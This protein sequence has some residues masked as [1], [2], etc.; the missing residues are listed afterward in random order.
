[1]SS[2]PS[3]I[4]SFLFLFLFL[5][6]LLP[7]L[8]TATADA[9]C[10][11]VTG[12]LLDSSFA[13]CKPASGAKHSGCCATNRASG[14]DICLDSGLCMSTTDK[15]AGTLWQ[16]GC[17]DSTWEDGGC[18]KNMC[19]DVSD[20][21][22]DVDAVV[23]S[24]WN[25]QM[26]DFGSY[27]CRAST[28]KGSCCDNSTAPTFTSSFLGAF[29][30]PTSTTVITS[31][32]SSSSSSTAPTSASLVCAKDKSAVVGGAVGGVLGAAIIG[33][34]GVIVWTHKKEKQQR[35]IKEHYEQQFEQSYALRKTLGIRPLDSIHVHTPSE[36]QAVYDSMGSWVT[37]KASD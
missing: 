26:C 4:H 27:C 21:L 16:N 23:S 6:L 2:L 9:K 36:K 13:P 5:L 35:R 37:Y 1:M 14:A 15:Y 3:L 30:L 34:V 28:A 7:T 31:S 18:P 8:V 24:A 22:K 33:L 25:V 20:N 11:S 29:Q 19:P 10:Y 32:S 17:T 12:K